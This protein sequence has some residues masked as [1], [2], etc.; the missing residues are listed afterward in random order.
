MLQ[1]LHHTPPPK[2]QGRTLK[3]KKGATIE[4]QSGVPG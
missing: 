3:Q 2:S 4:K 1:I